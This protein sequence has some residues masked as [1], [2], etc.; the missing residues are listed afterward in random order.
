MSK[1]VILGAVGLVLVVAAVGVLVVV[2]QLDRMIGDAVESY[3]SATTGTDVS[4]GSVDI[5]LSEGRGK[6]RGLTIANPDGFSTD[7]A[8]R[9]EDID[10]SLQLSS[11]TDD[12]PVITEALVDDAHLNVEQRGDASNVT[13]IQRHMSQSDAEQVP[14]AA[15]EEEGRIIIDRFRLTNARVTLTSELLSKPETI[16]LDDVVVSGIGRQSGGA[17]YGEATEAVLTPI[18]AAARTAA[19]N[20]LRDAAVGAARDEVQDEV[21]DRLREALERDE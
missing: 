13:A 10:L 11:L 12:V 7:Y 17:T 14:P 20:R 18:L 3:G 5:A 16:E 19:Q 2:T 15:G 9:L 21:R 8:L 4:L 6:L 1:K